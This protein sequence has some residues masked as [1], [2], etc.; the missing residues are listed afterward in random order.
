MNDEFKL[1]Y[2]QPVHSRPAR[3]A[4]TLGPVES[5]PWNDWVVTMIRREII[6]YE[7]ILLRSIRQAVDELIETKTRALEVEIGSLRADLTIARAHKTSAIIDLPDWRRKA[8]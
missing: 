2:S 3:P 7:K 4:A 5:E 8:S 1:R 6:L